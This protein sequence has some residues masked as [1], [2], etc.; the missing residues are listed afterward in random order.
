MMNNDILKQSDISLLF[1]DGDSESRLYGSHG[2]S[3]ET[4]EQLELYTLLDPASIDVGAFFTEDCDVI[5]YRQATIADA[6]Q[7]EGLCELL[8]RML[9]F[10]TD[11]RELRKMSGS[12]DGIGD[13]YLYS[14]S[15]IEIYTSL[16][17]LLHNEF[18]PLA[19]KL[20]SPAFI[21]FA[22]R[23]RLL[24]ES[25]YFKNLAEHLSELSSRVRDIRSITVGVN[26][27]RKLTP[28]SVGIISVNRYDTVTFLQCNRL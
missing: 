18:L 17:E 7:V 14:I 12:A 11:I 15:E 28:E 13:S 23:I 8:L 1:P 24:T 25:E 10:L 3:E 27:D 6:L 26:L 4:A 16:M 2:I 19:D 5:R 20:T 22:E 21:A 9:P